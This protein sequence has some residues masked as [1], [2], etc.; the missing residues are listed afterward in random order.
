MEEIS[1]NARNSS[2]LVTYTKVHMKGA[3]RTRN[4]IIVEKS[5]PKQTIF[6]L[7]KSKDRENLER[8]HKIKTPCLQRNK[9]KNSIRLLSLR[10]HLN[11]KSTLFKALKEKNYHLDTTTTYLLERLK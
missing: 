4:R 5:T 9:D 3:Q 11:K 6:K 7:P 1:N 2:K 8:S 10:K